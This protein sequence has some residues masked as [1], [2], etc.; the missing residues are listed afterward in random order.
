MTRQSSSYQKSSF[1]LLEGGLG[2]ALNFYFKNTSG[3][4]AKWWAQVGILP[5]KGSEVSSIRYFKSLAEAKSGRGYKSAPMDVT[6]LYKWQV[7]DSVTYK[8]KGGLIYVAG[9]GIAFA[10]FASTKLA[11]GTWETYVEK[12]ADTFVYVKITS[13]KLSALSSGPGLPFSAAAITDFKNS[14]DGFSYLIDLNLEDGRKVYHDL[15]RGNIMAAQQFASKIQESLKAPAVIKVEKF[16]RKSKGDGF[17]LFFGIPIL[18]NAT[19]AENKIR[20]HNVTDLYL[21]NS[22]IDAQFGMYDLTMRSRAFGTHA[23]TSKNFY[24][25]IYNISDLGTKSLKEKSQFGRFTWTYQD[26]NSSTRNLHRNME[27]LIQETGL[28]EV[29]VLIPDLALDLDF[30]NITLQITFNDLNTSNLIE[31]AVGR[32]ASLMYDWSQKRAKYAYLQKGEALCKSYSEGTSC[33]EEIINQTTYAAQKMQE[34]LSKMRSKMS[35]SIS[36]TTAYAEFGKAA[37]TNQVTLA[38]ALTMA[39]AGAQIDFSLEGTYFKAHRLSLNTTNVDG[40]YEWTTFYQQ[41]Q[42]SPLDPKIKRS[43]YHGVITNENFTGLG[44]P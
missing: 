28:N 2:A 22:K 38:M 7:G 11:Q 33:Q 16:K 43:R 35:N 17:S 34:A 27:S 5:M 18:L 15:V 14:D 40:R 4:M 25:V 29:K 23:T 37:M 19:T 39:G 30:T 8:S 10:G 3:S 9:T 6:V 44:A 1:E 26:D 13:S 21:D 32:S 20:S 41:D 42:S 24:G 12:V 31:S 36:Y